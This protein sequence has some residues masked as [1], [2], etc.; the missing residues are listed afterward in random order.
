[1][2]RL[3]K[4]TASLPSV[5]CLTESTLSHVFEEIRTNLSL[6][7]TYPSGTK[8]LDLLMSMGIAT[9]IP[10]EGTLTSKPSKK[11]YIFGIR[12]SQE[13]N[14]EPLELLQ[15]YHQSGVICYFSALSFLNLTS[16]L[17]THHHI[18]ILTRPKIK[19]KYDLAKILPET[20]RQ[21][22]KNERSRLGTSV[23]SYQGISYY[24]TKRV[25]K[26][27]PGIKTR[28]LSPWTK[29]RITTTE[30]TLL[31]TLQYPFHC[32][33][34]EAIFEAWERKINQIDDELILDY[35]KE[36]QIAP[37]ARRL[38]A[39]FELYDHHPTNRLSSF[40]RKLMRRFM[41]ESEFKTISLLRGIDYSRIN[42]NWNVSIP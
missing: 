28:S 11:F 3:S 35:L 5:R 33:G 34:P 32:G 31:D 40:L 27:I 41:T 24:S 7:S 8:I 21:Q 19:A 36:I 1:M 13:I 39:I 2:D 4:T 16:Q 20:I 9:R 25:K 22:K 10:I 18:A 30:Q 38:G 15:A 23:F 6:P 29:I 42:T 17:A 14:V 37:L 26:S 12:G